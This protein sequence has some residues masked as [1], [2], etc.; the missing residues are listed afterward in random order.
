MVAHGC[1]D[2]PLTVHPVAW[3]A[4]NGKTRFIDD[5]GTIFDLPEPI[6]STAAR[7]PELQWT[8][9]EDRAALLQ[10][11]NRWSSKQ[12][13]FSSQITKCETDTIHRLQVTL[14]DGTVV[15]WGA[16]N[17]DALDIR[18]RHLL[19]L[20]ENYH[21]TKTPAHLLFVTDDRL[22]MDMNWGEINVK[23]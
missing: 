9:D 18:T 14:A 7:L 20:L 12:P 16:I 2:R 13:A 17:A 3:F 15:D 23:T 21:P 19:R 10:C 5:K 11:L 6:P 4:Q 8:H 1:R 22:V